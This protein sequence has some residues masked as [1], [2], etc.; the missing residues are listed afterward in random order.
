MAETV[1]Q[2]RLSVEQVANI[3][4]QMSPQEKEKLLRLVP[5]L[6][7]VEP[8]EE[9]PT[10]AR[11]DEAELREYFL[12]R[13]EELGGESRPM[14][15]DDPFLGGLTVREY[16]EL[17]DEEDKAMW[18]RL[19]AEAEKEIGEYEEFEVKP[20]AVVPARQKHHS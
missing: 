17:S 9:K 20:D 7:K 18:D 5:D 1:T 14:Q 11:W 3:I 10:P 16:L 19:Y 2:E 12:K 13:M 4:R 8:R 15:D 6:Q